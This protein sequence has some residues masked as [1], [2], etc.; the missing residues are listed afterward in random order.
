MKKTLIALMLFVGM[1]AQAQEVYNELRKSNKAVVENPNAH[2]L[3]RHISQFKLDAL[4]YL[5]IKMQEDMPDS[6]VYFLDRQAM[7]MDNYVQLYIKKLV[8]YS[9]LPQN[10]IDEMTK[11]FMETSKNTPLFK[12]KDKEMTLNYY[13]WEKAYAIIEKK[14]NKK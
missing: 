11:M 2:T 12:D 10:M 14:I 4:D 7:A 13:A 5:A 3:A 6:T 8:E 9:N 1:N